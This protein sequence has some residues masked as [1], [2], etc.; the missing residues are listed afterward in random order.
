MYSA[1]IGRARERN[2]KVSRFRGGV[3]CAR[4]GETSKT[5]EKAEQKSAAAVVIVHF[6]FSLASSDRL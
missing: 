4:F 1:S 6:D 3:F 2:G 5:Q